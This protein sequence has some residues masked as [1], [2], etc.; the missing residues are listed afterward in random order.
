ML[1]KL[2]AAIAPVLFL[3]FY[4]YYKDKKAPEPTEQLFKAFRY[5]VLSAIAVMVVMS[6]FGASRQPVGFLQCLKVS[7]F[8]AGIPE[9][10]FK[11]LFLYILIWR[12]PQFDEYIDGIVYAVFISMGFA[13]LENVM[14]VLPG[15]VATAVTRALLSVPAHF[16]FA[17]IMG[18]FFSMGKF[19]PEN[20][21]RYMT[22]SLVL[23]I[24]AHGLFDTFAFWM[25]SLGE[26]R[27]YTAVFVFFIACDIWLWR[28]C[29]RL[30]RRSVIMSDE[31]RAE[32]E[33][34]AFVQAQ[35]AAER[36]PAALPASGEWADTPIAIFRVKQTEGEPD[37]AEGLTYKLLIECKDDSKIIINE[38]DAFFAKEGTNYRLTLPAGEYTVRA[39]NL[40]RY[41]QMTTQKVNLTQNRRITVAFSAWERI[42]AWART[43]S[44]TVV[45]IVLYRW[46]MNGFSI[47]L[48]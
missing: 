32:A 22:L 4:I 26:N 25:D 7:F 39:V 33:S 17:V 31:A 20:R 11:W 24:V 30:I 40:A 23:P 14:Y 48:W 6:P 15:S 35:E 16:L 21:S 19:H 1:I 2:L 45:A 38:R 9:E 41:E 12:S 27:L 34:L 28:R 44:I 47:G 29:T 18:Y 10:F 42:P 5:G 8:E 3:L 37:E 36:L 46:F 13:C 43:I